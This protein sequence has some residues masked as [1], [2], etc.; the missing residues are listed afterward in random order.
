MKSTALAALVLAPLISAQ[1]PALL[2]PLPEGWRFE[3]LPFP[4]EFAP[5][6]ELAGLEELAFA[7]GMFDADS[8][9][10]FSYAF[11]V[12]I[13]E[14]VRIDDAF[15]TDFLTRYYGGLCEAVAQGRFEFDRADLGVEVAFDGERYFATIDMIDAFVT[16]EALR[17]AFELTALPGPESSELFAIASPLPRDAAIWRELADY[18]AQWRA[19]QP[20]PVFLNHVFFVPDEET[21]AALAGSEFF[22]DSFAVSEVRTTDRGDTS[23]TGLYLY[24]RRTYF[25]FLQPGSLP[26]FDPGKTGL[27]FGVEEEGWST[28]ANSTLQQ[29]G[30]QVFAAPVTRRLGEDDVPW[31]RMLAVIGAHAETRMELFSM[32]YERRFLESWHAERAPMRTGLARRDVLTRYASALERDADA[33][34]LQD[35]T[36][37]HMNL[38]ERERQHLFALA[39]EFGYA[40]RQEGDTWT[41]QAPEYRMLIRA[42]AE[43]G[44]ITGLTMSLA[45]E[46]KKEVHRFGKASLA[47]HGRTAT[48]TLDA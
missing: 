22:R 15:V 26:G 24:G 17:L 1:E 30:F 8:D 36:E 19:E 14:D 35:I 21:Y 39:D 34:L 33:T 32:E 3:A 40:I 37:V 11:A 38:D 13:D 47:L 6:I 29:A 5:D 48:L 27:A 2:P 12:R 28:E 41:V 20:T 31:F 42:S 25:E 16:G 9:S 45:Q 43:P 7:P 44:R 4:L 18:R 46:R 10:Y 23:Y